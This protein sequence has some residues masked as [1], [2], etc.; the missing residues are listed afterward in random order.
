MAYPL[1]YLSFSRYI[2]VLE[3]CECL[4]CRLPGDH[5]VACPSSRSK[6]LKHDNF[7]W[8]KEVT[9]VI[10]QKTVTRSR[11][12]ILMIYWKKKTT[13]RNRSQFNINIKKIKIVFSPCRNAIDDASR[14]IYV[15]LQVPNIF[16]PRTF[17]YGNA[18]VGVELGCDFLRTWPSEEFL[19]TFS[20][21]AE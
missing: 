11:K 1:D 10:C 16:T 15:R 14:G 20:L 3:S 21:L 7:S 19:F 13:T 4:N 9:H 5:V 18:I 17:E 2:L 12:N 6:W 8:N